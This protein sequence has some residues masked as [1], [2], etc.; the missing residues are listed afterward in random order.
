MVL[1]DNVE[2]PFDPPT[3]MC[4]VSKLG[5]KIIETIQKILAVPVGS[6]DPFELFQ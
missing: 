5:V 6:Q 3:N 2:I 1:N 4:W